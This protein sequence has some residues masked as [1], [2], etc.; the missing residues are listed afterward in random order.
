M[1][2][3]PPEE[4]LLISAAESALLAF[5]TLPELRARLA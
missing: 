1:Q 3:A 5:L 4:N 2:P